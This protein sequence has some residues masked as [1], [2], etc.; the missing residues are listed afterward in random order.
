MYLG[1]LCEV[2]KP[3]DLY[4]KPAHPYTAALLGSIPVPDPSVQAHRGRRAGRRAALP[5]RAAE[6]LPV[7]HP[8]PEGAGHVRPGRAQD[9]PDR[10]RPLRGLPLPAR[11]RAGVRPTPRPRHELTRAEQRHDREPCD[12][13]EDSARSRG[14]A[15]ADPRR[16]RTGVRRPRPGRGHLRG[17]GRGR[18]RVTGARLQLLRRQGRPGRGGVHAQPPPPARRSSTWPSIP[19]RPIAVRLRAAIDCYLRF[20]RRNAGRLAADGH[21]RG[22]RPPRRAPRPPSALRGARRRLGG[23]HRR[24]DRGPGPGRLPRGRDAGLDRERGRATSSARSSCS[25]R[26]SGRACPRSIRLRPA[27]RASRAARQQYQAATLR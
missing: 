21:D 23:H 6:R 9:A 20:A 11:R 7:P 2:A 22:H 5:R 12:P 16:G 24:P 4:A 13:A 25:S 15:R 17:A 3:D 1:K 8:L 19:T 18:R 26:S 27:R 14:A 10:P